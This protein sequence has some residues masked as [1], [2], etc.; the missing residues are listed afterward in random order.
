MQLHLA[1]EIRIENQQRNVA[2]DDADAD[3]VL[4][5]HLL[6]LVLIRAPLIIGSGIGIVHSPT[7]DG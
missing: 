6:H 3:P 7:S 5:C 4:P 2:D 1:G